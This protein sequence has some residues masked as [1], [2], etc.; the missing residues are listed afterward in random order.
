[1]TQE[2]ELW[3]DRRRLKRQLLI[4]RCIAIFVVFATTGVTIVNHTGSDLENYIARLEITNVIKNDTKR[5]AT[6]NRL[7]NDNNVK[8]LIVSINSPGG[9]VVG[10]EALYRSILRIKNKIP[11]VAVMNE[12]ATSAGYMVAIAA[13]HIFAQKGTITGSIGVIFQTAEVTDLL[14]KIGIKVEAIKSAPLK[15]EPSIFSKITPSVRAVTQKLVDDMNSMFISMVAVSRKL[16]EKQ[17]QDIA[18]GRVFTGR[19][20]QKK[21]LID[22]IGSEFQARVWLADFKGID[23]SL[24]VRD[25]VEKPKL[26]DWLEHILLL[27]QKIAF[28]DGLRLDGLL[29]VWHPKLN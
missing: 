1:M 28:T 26:K 17:V 4:W 24:P 11:V 8:A 20:A 22:A 13:D 21:G 10:G 14:S 19:M 3:I 2:A 29:S 12:V 27:P 25:I 6:L 16:K 9:S 5:L 7:A 15:A 23:K 18:D